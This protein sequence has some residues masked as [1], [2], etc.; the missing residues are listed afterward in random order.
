MAIIYA[1]VAFMYIFLFMHDLSYSLSLEAILH[2]FNH[3]NLED[4]L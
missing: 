1:P 3:V 2:S 4:Y